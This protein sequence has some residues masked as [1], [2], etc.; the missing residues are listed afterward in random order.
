MISEPA[1]SL[2][3]QFV[4]WSS[5]QHDVLYVLAGTEVST[6]NPLP[7][8]NFNGI[9]VSASTNIHAGSTGAYDYVSPGNT[10]SDDAF[11]DGTSVDL[12]APGRFVDLTG[13]NDQT[14][15]DAGTSFAAPHVTGTVALLQ[16][17][18]NERIVNAGWNAV[19]SRRH[20]TMK[21]VLMN[22]ADKIIDN[23]TVTIPG[24]AQPAPP[25]TFL[26]MER[27]VIDLGPNQDGNKRQNWLESEAYGDDPFAFPAAYIP[28]DDQMGAGHLNAKRAVQQ[29]APGEYES[30]GAPVPAIGWDYGHTSG[31]GDNN[32][33]VISQSLLGGSFIS[34]T[35]AWD[36]GVTLND[37][38]SNGLFDF[39]ETFEPYT[40]FV[41]PADDVINDLDLYLVPAGMTID[42]AIATSLSAD[43]T[44]EH[45]FFRIPTTGHY[46]LWVNQ[47]DSDLGDGQDY[48]IAWW[49]AAA[50][51]GTSLGDYNG[52]HVVNASDYNTWKANFGTA[53]AAVDGNGDGIINAADYTVWRNHLGQMAGSGSAASVPEPNEMMLVGVVG[54]LLAWRRVARP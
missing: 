24:D 54:L 40:D 4:D 29:F 37:T 26:G 38:N 39:G 2:L 42:D 34:V 21:A 20:E 45:L 23:G 51:T 6:T 8:D 7:T 50:V 35:M 28:L 52:D 1:N 9:T 49:A 15:I 47:F 5:H 16:Q 41:P 33:Y 30:D 46:E 18:A 27:T 25:G 43:S 22:S 36:R 17:Y 44:I 19:N 48:A 14:R 10:F 53:N 3:T 31:A 32:K 12:L 11:G 13:R